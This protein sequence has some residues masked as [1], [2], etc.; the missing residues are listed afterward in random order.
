MPAIS[1]RLMVSSNDGGFSYGGGAATSA[2]DGMVRGVNV[3][4]SSAMTRSARSRLSPRLR[5]TILAYNTEARKSRRMVP[6]LMPM[7]SPA[8]YLWLDRNLSRLG[9]WCCWAKAR[10]ARYES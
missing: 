8:V 9:G 3:N 5:L 7:M 4:S 6:T 2:G 10:L 1:S